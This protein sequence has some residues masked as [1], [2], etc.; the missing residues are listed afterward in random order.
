MYLDD[1]VT[2]L[3]S[4]GLGTL[5]L[6]IFVGVKAVIPAGP[7]PFITLQG[8]GGA[9]S[10]G[11]HNSTEVPAYVKP[12][13]HIVVRCE[14]TDVAYALSVSAYN[15]IFKIRNQFIN[16]C[17]WRQ[18]SMVQ[19]PFELGEDEQGRPRWAFNV[20]CTKRQSPATS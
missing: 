5:D 12:S 18:V 9:H 15:G 6:N 7:G 1:L 4:A 11:T 3:E 19:E 10:E 16:G 20:D 13:A 8:T 17:W 14:D 2:V